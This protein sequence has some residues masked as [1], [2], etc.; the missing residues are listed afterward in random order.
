MKKSLI[1]LAALAA[2][3]AASAQSSVTIYGNLDQGY[4]SASSAGVNSS[5][6]NSNIASTSTLGFKGTEDLGSGLSANFN[7][8]GEISMKEGQ[9]GSTTT[10]NATTNGQKFNMFNRGATIGLASKTYGS[11]DVGRITDSAWTTQGSF[12]NSGMNSFGYSAVNATTSNPGAVSGFTGVANPADTTFSGTSA[13]ANG[14]NSGSAPFNFGSGFSYT[15]P[16]IAGFKGSVQ[17]F[18]AETSNATAASGAGKGM[19]YSLN[20]SNPMGIRL[21]FGHTDRN[22]NTGATAISLNNFG[23]EYKTGK[24]T[25]VA[26]TTK[27]TYEGTWAAQD[28]M[29]TTGLGVGYDLSPQVELKAAYSTLKSDLSSANKS[30]ITGL[31]A[32]YKLS[33]RTSLYGGMGFGSNTGT[34]NKQSV[35]YAGAVNTTDGASMKGYLVGIKHAF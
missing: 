20:Y 32:R 17:S 23:A 15:S 16:V 12:N 11:F 21:G 19:A 33:K 34:G 25:F 24:F 8:L 4:F 1:A 26:G 10:G 31:T 3:S 14:S 30:T 7:L 2:V 22:G 5:G 35:Y 27:T 6:M 18:G 29:T 13:T 9:M 28:S